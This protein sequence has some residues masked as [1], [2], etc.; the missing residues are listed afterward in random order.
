MST[1]YID[2]SDVVLLASIK[3]PRQITDPAELRDLRLLAS[4]DL[5]SFGSTME[6]GQNEIFTIP[7]A[8]LTKGGKVVLAFMLSKMKRYNKKNLR[9]EVREKTNS[10]EATLAAI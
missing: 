5:I 6:Q 10:M 9:N 1:D 4:Q 8:K 2:Y 7:T 3:K